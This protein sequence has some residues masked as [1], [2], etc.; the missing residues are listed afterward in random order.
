MGN[1][2]ALHANGVTGFKSLGPVLLRRFVK[3][4]G[5]IILVCPDELVIPQNK[6]LRQTRAALQRLTAV[7]G[8]DGC[9]SFWGF[10]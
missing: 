2:Y 10:P 4:P 7:E 3:S 5:P 8:V 1:P 9:E 6:I